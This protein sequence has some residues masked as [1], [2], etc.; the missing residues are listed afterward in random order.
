MTPVRRFEGWL[1]ILA[2]LLY[3]PAGCVSQ[4]EYDTAVRRNRALRQALRAAEER[5]VQQENRIS[6]LGRLLRDRKAPESE[7]KK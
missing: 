5:I 3:F 1:L 6:E 2:G 4:S 7:E